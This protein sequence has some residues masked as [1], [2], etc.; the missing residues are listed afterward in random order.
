MSNKQGQK[1][2]GKI[3]VITGGNSGI[4]LATAKRFVEEGAHAGILLGGVG[5]RGFS[6]VVSSLEEIDCRI[7]DAVYQAV[8]LSDAPRPTTS[9][10]VFQGFG[11]SQAFERIPHD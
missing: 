6:I 5:P 10:H 7:G 8:F 4:G 11:L 1:L 9:Q 3:A 2:A